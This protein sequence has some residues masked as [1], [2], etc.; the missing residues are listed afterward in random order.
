[1]RFRL[2][3]LVSTSASLQNS[4]PVHAT[5]PRWNGDAV[6][7]IPSEPTACSNDATRVSGTL[8]TT[9]F[10]AIVVR[11]VPSPYSSAQSAIRRSS[12]GRRRPAAT[13]NRVGETGLP[14][15]V[16][17][18]VVAEVL[19][20]RVFL[21][22][23]GIERES[24]PMI[25]LREKPVSRPTLREEEILHASLGP[26]HAE[27]IR[28]AEDARDR[29]RDGDHLIPLDERVEADRHVGTGGEAATDSQ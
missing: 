15:R 2:N 13:E 23:R 12:D 11:S 10:C 3:A 18:H 21:R 14:L 9:R 24:E 27:Y 4:D 5:I 8:S 17:A 25:Q 20:R 28:I 1:M 26:A 29:F 19:G 16:N 6:G 22:D 7:A